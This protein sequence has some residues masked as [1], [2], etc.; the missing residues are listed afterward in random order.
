MCERLSSFGTS[1]HRADEHR[2]AGRD[3][4]DA[5]SGGLRR[6]GRRSKLCFRRTDVASALQQMR[7]ARPYTIRHHDGSTQPLEA[8][9]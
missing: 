3:G 7:D 6:D 4:A 1:G 2:R 8:S 5:F 9:L